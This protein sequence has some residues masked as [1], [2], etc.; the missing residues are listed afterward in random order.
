MVHRPR[1]I[2][3]GLLL[4]VGGVLFTGGGCACRP[5]FWIRPPQAI[6]CPQPHLPPPGNV[7]PPSHGQWPPDNGVS[8]LSAQTPVG[9]APMPLGN[10]PLPPASS[11]PQA[12]QQQMGPCPHCRAPQASGPAVRPRR[13]ILRALGRLLGRRR[14]APGAC[15]TCG[16]PTS[17][18]DGIYGVGNAQAPA[19]YYNDPRFFP[20]PTRPAFW[21]R[22][23]E[24]MAAV[25]RGYPNGPVGA[26]AG[27][28]WNSA[29]P[30]PS[31]SVPE[32]EVLPLPAPTRLDE[33]P[34]NQGKPAG[35]REGQQSWIFTPPAVSPTSA[36]DLFAMRTESLEKRE[37]ALLG[38]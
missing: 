25:P 35:V 19:C 9:S 29:R 31:L 11:V 2:A 15:G 24:R 18:A 4:L 6:Y 8:Q 17:G 22:V 38:W 36:N 30:D 23:D 32:P 26:P 28:G 12:A 20:V 21:P 7:P 3:I 27:D 13:P 33:R 1:W 16:Q 37:V 14:P 10:A 34:R 5:T